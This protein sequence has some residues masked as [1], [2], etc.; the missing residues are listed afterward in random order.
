MRCWKKEIG[1]TEGVV[2]TNG[3]L[4]EDPWAGTK[5]R[6][7]LI[8]L[9]THSTR[10]ALASWSANAIN[11]SK[12]FWKAKPITE[13]KFGPIGLN[14]IPPK[15][16]ARLISPPSTHQLVLQNALH[17]GAH[18]H[19]HTRILSCLRRPDRGEQMC[20]CTRSLF[21][22]F[23]PIAGRCQ[24]A[25]EVGKTGSLRQAF[26]FPHLFAVAPSPTV[27]V[28]KPRPNC[29]AQQRGFHDALWKLQGP[30]TVKA[31]RLRYQDILGKC[32]GARV[33]KK[34]V[35]RLLQMDIALAKCPELRGCKNAPT[36][37]ES[38]HCLAV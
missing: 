7:H 32:D 16:P 35:Q 1:K 4:V 15:F 20:K 11:A 38:I 14:G 36:P 3:F 6:I 33:P 10:L 27:C 23:Y 12:P 28:W 19:L 29:G 5:K 8:H 18:G 17:V 31:E 2:S 24:H 26:G 22:N 34:N 30:V 25:V 37:V 9:C 21:R 13:G